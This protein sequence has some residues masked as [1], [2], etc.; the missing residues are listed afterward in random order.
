[1]RAAWWVVVLAACGVT[2]PVPDGGE[3]PSWPAGAVEIGIP[4]ETSNFTTW[5]FQDMPAEVELHAGAQGGFHLPTSFRV[6]GQSQNAATFDYRVRRA[7]DGV[8]VS[9]GTRTYDVAPMDGGS[10][11]RPDIVIFL[12]PTPVGVNVVGEAL[13]FEV[14]VSNE[15]GAILGVGT[16]HALLKCPASNGPFCLSVCKG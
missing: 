5:G 12:C 7:R 3:P 8:L 2:P 14:S 6:N 4:F 1:M 13:D 11:V 16:A 9:K 15:A 10:W